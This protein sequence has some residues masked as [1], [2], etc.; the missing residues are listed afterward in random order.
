ML[1]SICSTDV[2]FSQDSTKAAD[3]SPIKSKIAY[4][5]QDSVRFDVKN[6]KMYL[7]GD[8]DVKYETM[9]LK[10]DYIEFDM[11]KN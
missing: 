8:A 10:A 2:V 1:I 5:S 6:Q 9:E 7:Y 3:G 4:N 11:S